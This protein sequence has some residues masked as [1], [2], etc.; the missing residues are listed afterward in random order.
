VSSK[1]FLR[2]SEG[3]TA[4]E[5]V[6]APLVPAPSRSAREG[7][8]KPPV[9]RAK[10]VLPLV[11]ALRVQGVEFAPCVLP[12]PA[13]AAPAAGP[14][15]NPASLHPPHTSFYGKLSAPGS[16]SPLCYSCAP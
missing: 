12:V 9:P 7:A 3:V 16:L 8:S 1:P 6:K 10:E 4:G 13:T 15:R 14:M 11:R 5:V 2:K